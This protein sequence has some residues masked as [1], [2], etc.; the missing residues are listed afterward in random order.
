MASDDSSFDED[1]Y[2]SYGGFNHDYY[3]LEKTFP[4]LH[5]PIFTV[6][7]FFST[8]GAAI[9]RKENRDR[10]T[11]PGHRPFA[12]PPYADWE[13]IMEHKLPSY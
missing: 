7:H 5:L 13:P 9:L 1:H 4:T 2:L 6:P 12:G 11:T 10:W 3:L 8:I